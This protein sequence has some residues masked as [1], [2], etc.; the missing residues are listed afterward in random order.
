MDKERASKCVNLSH[1][2]FA[3][4]TSVRCTRDQREGLA[5]VHQRRGPFEILSN[6]IVDI[7]LN[8]NDKTQLELEGSCG[9]IWTVRGGRFKYARH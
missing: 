8:C 2:S 6:K 3:F 7:E 1:I 4:F 9:S 5:R